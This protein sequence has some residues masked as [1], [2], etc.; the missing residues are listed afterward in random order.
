M[1]MNAVAVEVAFCLPASGILLDHINSCQSTFGIINFHVC[2]RRVRVGRSKVLL[3]PSNQA[4]QL[5]SLP[6]R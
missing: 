1:G 4:S 3:L 2:I 6:T 5:T